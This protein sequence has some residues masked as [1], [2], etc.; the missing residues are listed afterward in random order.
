MDEDLC[1]LC[2]CIQN[3]LESFS[4]EILD[5]SID[6]RLSTLSVL[7]GAVHVGKSI[8]CSFWN[9]YLLLENERANLSI[10]YTLKK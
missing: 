1:D 5:E 7:P 10:L 4:E 6:R 8:K 9:W 2:P 3:A